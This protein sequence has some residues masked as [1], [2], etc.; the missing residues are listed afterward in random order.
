VG[1]GIPSPQGIG[2]PAGSGPNRRR[3]AD[4]EHQR[5][6]MDQAQHSTPVAVSDHL[7]IPE[8][9]ASFGFSTYKTGG[10]MARSMMLSELRQLFAAV[11]VGAGRPEYRASILDGNALG[12]P[13][14]STRKKS[15]KYLHQLYGLDPALALFRLL[16]RF[17]AEDP[18][19]LPPGPDLRFCR[20]PSL[21]PVLT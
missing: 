21:R 4:Q 2:S 19:S 9:A 6:L 1:D 14:F 18:E 8:A 15:D 12:K 13:T 3:M 5:P 7:R 10:H 11:P 20:T 17:A 16:R